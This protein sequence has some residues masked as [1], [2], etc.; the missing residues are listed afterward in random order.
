MAAE[1]V[2]IPEENFIDHDNYV[3]YYVENLINNLLQ[4]N[5]NIQTDN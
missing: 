3:D 4:D 5:N 1:E 2:T